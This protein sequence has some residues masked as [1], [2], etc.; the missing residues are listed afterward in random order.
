MAK[1]RH[2]RWTGQVRLD[3]AQDVRTTA[4]W[5]N[6]GRATLWAKPEP[7]PNMA[8]RWAT[9][10]SRDSMVE[11]QE[12]PSVPARAARTIG[13]TRDN[14]RWQRSLPPPAGLAAP[15]RWPCAKARVSPP[16]SKPRARQPA[17]ERLQRDAAYVTDPL[18]SPRRGPGRS[19]RRAFNCAVLSSGTVLDAPKRVG[20][21]VPAQRGSSSAPSGLP[22][23][24]RNVPVA[25]HQRAGRSSIRRDE[26]FDTARTRRDHRLTSRSRPTHHAGTDARDLPSTVRRPAARPHQRAGPGRGADDGAGRGGI[27]QPPA[28][29]APGQGRRNCR[30]GRLPGQ[31]RI[32]IHY[33]YRPS[34][35][36]WLE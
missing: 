30:A 15:T 12:Q 3:C 19:G 14:R 25:R 34:H 36:R 11:A 35:R 5:T 24:R 29:G 9:A 8:T 22:P 16:T 18:R 7:E 31:R 33:R 27:R 20:L 10:R 17:A 4:T 13:T 21:R 23:G 6:P 32:V 1:T 28:D 26:R 2:A